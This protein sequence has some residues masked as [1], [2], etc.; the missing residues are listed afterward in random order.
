LV[1]AA[2]GGHL[3]RRKRGSVTK[4]SKKTG[5]SSRKMNLS[6]RR[7]TACDA[8]KNRGMTIEAQIKKLSHK[9][10]AMKPSYGT[11][12]IKERKAGSG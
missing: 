4:K 11:S 12:E 5:A 3:F 6:R 2:G 10:G 7:G 1:L 9:R 8:K